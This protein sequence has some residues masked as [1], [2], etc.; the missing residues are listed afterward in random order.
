M[1][2]DYV[3]RKSELI[4]KLLEHDA[5]IRERMSSQL[6]HIWQLIHGRS[7]VEQLSSVYG[8]TRGN[9]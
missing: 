2:A 4:C 8:A 7:R 5:E 6:T 1:D 9:A 3:R